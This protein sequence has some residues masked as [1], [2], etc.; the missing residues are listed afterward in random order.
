[1]DFKSVPAGGTR[2][3]A[4][5][6]CGA[7]TPGRSTGTDALQRN[8]S[9]VFGASGQSSPVE[10]VIKVPVVLHRRQQ[11]AGGRKSDGGSGT[12]Q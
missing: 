11:K 3:P 1:M 9:L 4:A 2:T 8:N 5:V 7:L 12:A 6:L 10:L